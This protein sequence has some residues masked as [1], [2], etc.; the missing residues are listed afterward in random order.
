MVIL[1]INVYSSY[2]FHSKVLIEK[3]K[4]KY[5]IDE[6]MN[7]SEELKQELT[8]L[9]FEIAEEAKN[10][11]HILLSEPGH[12]KEEGSELH[13]EQDMTDISKGLKENVFR[14]CDEAEIYIVFYL[15]LII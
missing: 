7:V 10:I 13:I 4:K 9:S 14:I 3:V 8:R 5:L 11:T 15:F 1:V 12:S 6:N 2:K